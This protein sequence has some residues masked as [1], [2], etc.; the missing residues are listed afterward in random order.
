MALRFCRGGGFDS[1]HVTVTG[2]IQDVRKPGVE[3]ALA[4]VAG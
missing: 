3:Q 2:A 1:L 4:P